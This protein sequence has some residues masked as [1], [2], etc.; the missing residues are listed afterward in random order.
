M[1]KLD[2]IGHVYGRLTVKAEEPSVNYRRFFICTCSCG[3]KAKVSMSHLR[4]GHTTSCGCLTIEKPPRFRHGYSGSPLYKIWVQM[5]DR[6]SNPNNASYPKYGAKGVEVCAEWAD[7]KV[8]IEWALTNGY[9]KG[10]SID[11][12]NAYGHYHPD[13]CRWVNDAVQ[14]I[15]KRISV[16]NTSGFVGVAKKQDKW[17]ARVT[18]GGKRVNIGVFNT[19]DEANT[20]RLAYINEN[21]L[22][23]HLNAYENQQ[24]QG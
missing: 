6:C 9:K 2:L 19:P 23:E 16:K 13:N 1:A 10:L 11:R 8:F 5:W 15:N 21:N 14:A 4:T 20:A 12:K 22:T 18:V 17:S 3:G 7:S 24:R